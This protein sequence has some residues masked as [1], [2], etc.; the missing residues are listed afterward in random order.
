[1]LSR[2]GGQLQV[3]IGRRSGCAVCDAGQGCGAGLFGRLLNQN[4]VRLSLESGFDGKPGQAVTLGLPESL[5]LKWVWSL[6]GIPLLAGLAGAGFAM[7]MSI[8]L[9][10][11]GGWVDLL[12]LAG[13]LLAAWPALKFRN[14]TLQP[15]IG[16][17]HLS[18]T[19]TSRPGAVCGGP[20]NQGMNEVNK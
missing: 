18:I 12:V 11:N 5:F 14:R 8:Y 19:D 3:E 7:A 17:K 1:V 15:E 10:L 2:D 16:S 6:Y 4:P 20:G 13:A 9:G